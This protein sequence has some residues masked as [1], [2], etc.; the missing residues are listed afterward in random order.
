MEANPGV[1]FPLFSGKIAAKGRGCGMAAFFLAAY[2]MLITPIQIGLMVKW[3]QGTASVTLG[4]MAW[5]L[6]KQF[7]FPLVRGPDG[8]L[9]LLSPPALRHLR[10]RKKAKKNLLLLPE[11]LLYLRKKLGTRI[12]LRYL[13]LQVRIALGNAGQTALLCGILSALLAVFYPRS[14]NEILPAPPGESRGRGMCVLSCR[15]AAM[16]LAFIY[17]KISARHRKKKE[18]VLW[19]TQL[20]T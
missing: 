9:R 11:R 12:H 10:R 17:W 1:Y 2:L 3:Q 13:G 8:R 6:R 20:D 4:L 15:L 18:D 19:N 16:G 14:Q 5:G 7:V